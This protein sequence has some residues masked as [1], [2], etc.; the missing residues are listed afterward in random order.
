MG[1]TLAE[2]TEYMSLLDNDPEPFILYNCDVKKL[3]QGHY[4]NEIQF[5]LNSQQ[6]KSELVFLSSIR[7]VDVVSKIN[8][9]KTLKSAGESL[10][11]ATM[12]T[13]NNL[14]PD[15]H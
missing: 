15:V 7:S 4:G 11:Q 2:I 14:V 3:L 5:A 12:Q 6:N 13:A 10:R 1:F 9:I 8:R